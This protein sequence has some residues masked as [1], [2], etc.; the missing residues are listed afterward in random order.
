MTK[1]EI[2]AEIQEIHSALTALEKGEA[3]VTS[4]ATEDKV[5]TVSKRKAFGKKQIFCMIC[6]KG[7]TTLKRHLKAAHDMSDK[8][9]RQEFDIPRTQPLAAKDYTESRRKMAIDK[10]LAAGLAK[11]RAAKGKIKKK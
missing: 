5:P 1:D 6:G 7:F 8:E 2:I 9:Y 3:V 11:A 4:Q 10:G